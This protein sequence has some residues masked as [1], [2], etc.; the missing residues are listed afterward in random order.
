ML[1]LAGLVRYIKQNKIDLIH[2]GYRPRDAFYGVLIAK[3]AGV[4]TIVHVH[5]EYG[6][7]I[8]GR[9]RWAMRQADGIMTISQFVSRSVIA[10]GFAP[11]KVYCVLN[12]IDI[13]RWNYNTDRQQVREEF[14]LAPDVPLLVI[15][16]RVVPPKGHQL[17]LAALAIVKKQVPQ[18]KLLIVGGE[19]PSGGGLED[20]RLFGPVLQQQVHELQLDENVVFTGPRSDIQ[21][22]LAASDIF[23]MPA[24]GEGFGLSFAEAMAMKKPVVALDEA[25]TPEVVEHGK[26]GLLSQPGDVQQLAENILTLVKDPVLCKQMGEYGRTRIEQYFN[27]ER[28]ARDAEQVYRRVLK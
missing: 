17:L 8:G 3:L 9:V 27:A 26:S 12:G 20:G 19:D 4:R 10:A 13:S 1:N 14:G 28:M 24:I 18:I 25:G 16:S 6:D 2:T 22:I 15:I 11:E 5:S 7:W 21:H 23:T